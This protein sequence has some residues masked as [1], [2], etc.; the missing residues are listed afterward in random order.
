MPF[1]RRDFVSGIAMTAGALQL[2]PLQAA[3]KGLLDPAAIGPDYYPPALTGLRGSHAGAFEVAHAL[4][5]Q[6]SMPAL[7]A[8]VV[9]DVYDLV[10]VGAG[11]SGLAAAYFF[12]EEAGA[13][14]RILVLDNHD[15]FGG[16]AKRNEF[17]AGGRTL[18]GYGGSQSID[19]P[20][21]Y[22]RAAIGL[23]R[24]LG[25]DVARFHTYY[26]K[27]FV[28]RHGLGARLFLDRAHYGKDV[29][30]PDPFST[31]W[32]DINEAPDAAAIINGLPLSDAGKKALISLHG[33]TGDLLA[34]QS[35][36]QKITTLRGMS[37]DDF[38]RRVA[39]MPEEVVD[40]FNAESVGLWAVGYDALSALE[41]TREGMPGTGG[42]GLDEVLAGDHPHNDPYIFHFPEGNAGVARLLVRALV[43]ASASGSTMEDIV[44]ARLHYE[45]LDRP[46]NP[47]R[48]RLNSTV[49]DVRHVQDKAAVDVCYARGGTVER[50]RAKHVVM[51]CWNHVIPH[52]CP[53]V[54][55]P[56]VEA[57]RFPEKAPL[58]YANVALHNWRAPARAGMY[59]FRAPRDFFSYGMLD[60]PVSLPGYAFSASPEEPIILHMVH[61][62]RVRG[63]PIREQYR[64]GRAQLLS[65]SFTDFE[66][67][68]L[69]MLQSMWGSHDFDAQKD[70]AGITVNRWPH[71]YSYEYCDLVDP[72]E[73]TPENGP[74]ITARAKIGRI[75]IAN[76]DSHARAYLDAAIDAGFRAA[77]EQSG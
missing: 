52:I 35:A 22:S 53:D 66:T 27:G 44:T 64:Q 14:A 29:L 43:P 57:M 2:S 32:L 21:A 68:I 15:D 25:I 11:V 34:G 60:F 58:V 74:H 55:A 45:T 47:A 40:F 28:K 5:L 54:P 17:T 72:P 49:L 10:V 4:A 23:L 19:T 63:L 75:S 73:W 38:L 6:G 36:E 7:P 33:Q 56:Q 71:G 65:L 13:S 42:L 70:I 48:I 76:A 16:H 67:H 30:T 77:R 24:K 20:S 3:A 31:R 46:S 39:G 18:I 41:A 9:D 61:T 37:Y 26:D 1:T 50:V 12:R 8:G 51:A 69:R 59:S 62:P